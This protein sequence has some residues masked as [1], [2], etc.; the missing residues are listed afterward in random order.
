MSATASIFKGFVQR[1]SLWQNSLSFVGRTYCV[2]RAVLLF[3]SVLLYF[4]L[5]TLR[6]G[7]GRTPGR[8]RGLQSCLVSE[9]GD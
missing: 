8:L 6:S 7:S 5:K 3:Y 1:C 4:S 9:E 2:F